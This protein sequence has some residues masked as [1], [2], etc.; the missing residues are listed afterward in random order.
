MLSK[1]MDFLDNLLRV[2]ALRYLK[3]INFQRI[4]SENSE[5]L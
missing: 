4:T 1:K 5:S 3:Y 2:A